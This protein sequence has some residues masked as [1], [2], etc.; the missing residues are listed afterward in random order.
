MRV[1]GTEVLPLGRRWPGHPQLPYSSRLWSWWFEHL[2]RQ[3]L[4]DLRILTATDTLS[5]QLIISCDMLWALSRIC[6][7]WSINMNLWINRLGLFCIAMCILYTSLGAIYQAQKNITM[8]GGVSRQLLYTK[9]A[10]VAEQFN[11]NNSRAFSPTGRIPKD[12]EQKCIWMYMIYILTFGNIWNT[13]ALIYLA[14][15]SMKQW[16]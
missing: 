9:K 4:S 11:K 14:H 5:P 1:F 3:P 6:D 15:C 8:P 16:F 10:H 12:A 2:W 13:N 7:T